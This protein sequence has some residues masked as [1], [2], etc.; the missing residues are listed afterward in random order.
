[1]AGIVNP[2]TMATVETLDKTAC[3]IHF[4]SKI[5]G[6]N[7]LQKLFSSREPDFFFLVSSLASVLG[8]LGFTPYA[9]ANIYMDSLLQQQNRLGTIPWIAVNWDNWLFD[10][11]DAGTP[12]PL[13][14][15]IWMNAEEGTGALHRVMSAV[16]DER[17]VHSLGDLQ[18]R[19]E[20]WLTRH[21]Q[22][23]LTNTSGTNRHHSREYLSSQY[24]Q[25]RCTVEKEVTAVWEEFFGFDKLGVY[26]DFFEVGGDSLKAVSLVSLM[27]D[28]LA[29]SLPIT[30]FFEKPTIEKVS[31]HAAGLMEKGTEGPPLE[32]VEK[33]EYYPATVAQQ[34]L[35][36]LS[37]IEGAGTASNISQALIV[38][39]AVDRRLMETAF[40]K[41]IERHESL[42]TTF[43]ALEADILMKIHDTV[44]F[45]LEYAE[46][47]EVS[48]DGLEEIVQ[49][50]PI[51]F[52][53]EQA[54]L[55]RLKLLKYPEKQ[56]LLIFDIHHIIADDV[57]VRVL[58]KEF[59][60]L[61]NGKQL[62]PMELQYKDYAQWQQ[63]FMESPTFEEMRNYWLDRFSGSVPLLDMPTD[64]PRPQYQEF[65]GVWIHFKL[66]DDLTAKLRTLSEETGTTLYMVLLAAMNTLFQKYSGQ[67]DITIASPVMGRDYRALDNIIGLF[68]NLLPMRNFPA[69]NKGFRDFLKE[70]KEN[71]LAAY[72]NQGHPFGQLVEALQLQKDYSRN[73]L[74]DVELIMVNTDT[75][76][77]AIDGVRFTPYNKSAG[78]SMVDIIL[79][80]TEVEERVSFKLMYCSKLFKKETMERWLNS[81]KE[82]LDVVSEPENKDI[83]LKDISISTHLGEAQSVFLGDTDDFGF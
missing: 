36:M 72:K 61:Y 30:I 73:P 17:V 53:L 31:K 18:A 20:R 54:P 51:P 64:F 59:S 69:E 50:Y 24:Q 80:V 79:E 19:I 39:G 62:P 44:D 48:A 15:D 3:E 8:G 16:A 1:A 6:L 81:F 37:R 28:R 60:A 34:K 29:I 10:A 58:L 4:Q 66:E 14:I 40:R 7:V 5:W 83:P 33:K 35:Y 21:P 71:A 75:S 76:M 13:G 56:H 68:I 78:I 23:D 43:H 67:E 63:R 27:N 32:A 9:A 26:D 38:E 2:E 11:P 74:N 46:L 52:D 70:V 12:A 55:M 25:P 57:S 45:H 65:D 82:I 49:S 22:E 41:V 47:T 77:L 42:R